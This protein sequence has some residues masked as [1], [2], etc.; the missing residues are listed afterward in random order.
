MTA[1]DDFAEGEL[2]VWEDPSGVYLCAIV[3][4]P[5]PEDWEFDDVM[6]P[7]YSDWVIADASCFSCRARFRSTCNEAPYMGV[8]ALSLRPLTAE[9]RRLWGSTVDDDIHD[10]A[11]GWDIEQAPKGRPKGR[12]TRRGPVVDFTKRQAMIAYRSSINDYFSYCQRFHTWKDLVTRLRQE[13]LITKAQ[14][15][16]WSPPPD[17]SPHKVGDVVGCILKHGLLFSGIVQRARI[18]EDE[19][20]YEVKASDGVIRQVP[21]SSTFTFERNTGRTKLGLASEPTGDPAVFLVWSS[22]G[23]YWLVTAR[24]IIEAVTLVPWCPSEMISAQRYTLGL[25]QALRVA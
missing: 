10:D 15:G 19:V 16:S 6:I 22:T 14:H 8:S 21:L 2:A 17:I 13:G 5:T 9:E 24:S 25:G 4:R 23:K 20:T 3:R 18:G 12:P 11:Q 1:M 7:P